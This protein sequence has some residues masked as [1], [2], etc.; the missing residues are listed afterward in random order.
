MPTILRSASLWILALASIA[1]ASIQILV[2]LIVFLAGAS[3]QDIPG[4]VTV[5][6]ILCAAIAPLA[7]RLAVLAVDRASA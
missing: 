3:G 5:L 1:I 7:I 4:S 2:V 6:T